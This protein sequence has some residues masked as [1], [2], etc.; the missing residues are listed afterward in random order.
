LVVA[1][2]R[3]GAGALQIELR[4]RQAAELGRTQQTQSRVILFRVRNPD[5]LRQPAPAEMIMPEVY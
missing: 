3:H 4:I 5:Y 1:V 2:N